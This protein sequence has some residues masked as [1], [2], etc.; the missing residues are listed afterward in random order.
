MAAPVASVDELFGLLAG[1]AG[2]IDDIVAGDTEID[3]LHHSLQCAEELVAAAPADIELQVAGL[4]HDLGHL[5]VPGDPEGHGRHA[6]DA[7][8]GLLGDRVAALVELHVPAKRYLVTTD[9][10]YA[11][12]LSPGSTTSLAHQGGA[13]SAGERAALEADPRLADALTLRRADEAAKDPARVVP[14]LDHWR[15]IVDTLAA[16]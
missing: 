11:S 15:P 1:T 13:L 4:V 6:A 5:L 2:F 14:G 10:G 12:L 3:I 8:R 16:F 7:L 9:P